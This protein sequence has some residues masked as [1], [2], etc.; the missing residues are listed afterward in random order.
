MTV[1]KSIPTELLDSLLS[2]YQTPE[3]LIGENGLL[4]QLTKALV[5]RALEAELNLFTVMRYDKSS[6]WRCVMIDTSDTQTV[7]LFQVIKPVTGHAKTPAERMRAYRQRLKASGKVKAVP[8]SCH[9]RSASTVGRRPDSRDCLVQTS[10]G[11]MHSNH[12][13]LKEIHKQRN[14]LKSL[15]NRVGQSQSQEVDCGHV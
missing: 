14:L 2:G 3:D 11:L 6:F 15:L 9:C 12:A 1:S 8:H 13:P 5:G 7:D 4:K 10:L